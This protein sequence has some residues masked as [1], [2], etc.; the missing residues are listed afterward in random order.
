MQSVYAGG[1]DVAPAQSAEAFR[2]IMEAMARPGTLHDISGAQA[3]GLSVAGST[4]LL[5]LS[6]PD[7]GVY[8]AGDLD[9][10]D[11]RNWIAFH[12]GAPVVAPNEA[13]FALGVWAQLLPLKTY[14]N[15][16]AEY[17]DRSATLIVEGPRTE[18]VLL[19]GPGIKDS[20]PMTVP[21]VAALQANAAQFP[22]GLDFIFTHGAQVAALPRSSQIKGAV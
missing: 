11:L 21:A 17:P 13:D 7:T 12:T 9:T 4:V 3:P 16:T 22:L 18:P 5:V 20:A 19:A 2:A 1:F 14:K 15:G 10:P 6:D 8:L